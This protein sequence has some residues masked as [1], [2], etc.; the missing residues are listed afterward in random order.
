MNI[1]QLRSAYSLEG[2][3]AIVTGAS[4]PNGMGLAIVRKLGAR[5]AS[6]VITD[7]PAVREDVQ[8]N[9]RMASGSSETLEQALGTLKSEGLEVAGVPVDVTIPEHV[10]ACVAEAEKTF[11]GVDIVVNN[12]GVFLGEKPFFELADSAWEISWQ[13]HVKGAAEFCKAAIPA[14]R[15]RG[16]GVII[17]NASVAGLIGAAEFSAYGTTKSATVALTKNLA[18]EFGGENIRVHA[19]CPGNI[20]T[21]VS[22]GE[23]E[24]FAE[25]HGVSVAEVEQ[26]ML[27]PI[28]L[29]R[30]GTPDDVAEVVAFL[31]A[32]AA[33]YLTGLAVPVTGGMNAGLV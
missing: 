19:V 1:E 10:H 18:A 5:G 12:A 8:L 26:M 25:R 24:E 2:K 15:K 16:G 7:L 9:E 11:G 17:N 32:P 31:A 3:V 6:L 33:S 23:A 27:E 21:D 28:A 22:A 14:M 30:Y 29:G 20:N 13:V 4:K